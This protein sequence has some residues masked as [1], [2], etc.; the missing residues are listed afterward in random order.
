VSLSLILADTVFDAGDLELA[1]D[2]GE[3]KPTLDQVDSVSAKLLKAPGLQDGKPLAPTGSEKI[4]LIGT[5]EEARGNIYFARPDFE[6]ELEQ[7]RD[8]RAFF[9]KARLAIIAGGHF[10]CAQGLGVGNGVHQAAAN[11]VIRPGRGEAAHPR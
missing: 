3:S 6:Q 7:I 8:Q 11:I 2:D 10:G 5:G 1:G 9:A 4:K